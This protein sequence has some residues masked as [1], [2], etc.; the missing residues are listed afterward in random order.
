M[1]LFSSIVCS[2]VLLDFQLL[3]SIHIQYSYQEPQKHEAHF[4]RS[5]S[6][7]QQ[8]VQRLGTVQ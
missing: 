4:Y 1:E 2:W 5:P 6:E 3:Y 8:F 7:V